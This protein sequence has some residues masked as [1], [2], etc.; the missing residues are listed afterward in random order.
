MSDPRFAVFRPST[1]LE[2]RYHNGDTWWFQ[3]DV[4]YDLLHRASIRIIGYDAPE[5]STPLG[6]VATQYA[7][8][9]LKRAR[10]ILIKTTERQSGRRWLGYVQV[11][12]ADFALLLQ[13]G[14]DAGYQA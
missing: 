1:F 7:R 3:I 6:P 8:A 2:D 5:R 9:Q 13:A 12:G 14:K 11:D 10:E 4:G